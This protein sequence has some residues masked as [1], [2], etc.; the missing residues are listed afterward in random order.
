MQRY[1]FFDVDGTVIAKDSF[2]RLL[3]WRLKT[4]PWRSL[5]L[6]LLSPV[7]VATY[8]FKLDRRHAKSALLWSLTCFKGKRNIVRLL[9]HELPNQLAKDWFL[10]ANSELAALRASGH[11]ICYVSASGQLWLRGLLR[12]TDTGPKI[13]I[14]SRLGIRFC[15]AVLTSPN[16]YRHE[17][18]IRIKQQLGTEMEWSAAYSD[19]VADLPLLTAC[20][21]RTVVNPKSKH[22]LQFEKELPK[23]F[24]IVKWRTASERAENTP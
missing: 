20:K 18:I 23:P 16:C 19:H 8:L 14:G 7:F 17:K 22:I 9:A 1:A 3:R 4:E 15:G 6:I 10:E 24:R 5:P 13:I 2:F 11:S 21:Q 12:R